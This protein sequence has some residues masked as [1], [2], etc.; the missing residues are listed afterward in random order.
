MFCPDCGREFRPGASFCDGCGRPVATGA[1]V[2]GEADAWGPA[3]G[4][5]EADIVC[6]VGEKSGYYLGNFRKFRVGRIE[7][8]APTWNWSAFL[9]GTWWF[10]YRKMYPWA[11]LAFV[12]SCIPIVGFAA[13]IATGIAGNYIYWRHVSAQI[14]KARTAT[15]ESELPAT[16][17][18]MGGVHAWVIWVGIAL[19]ILAFVGI[20]AAISIPMFLK[21]VGEGTRAI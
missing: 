11:L 3:P 13:W 8:F 12:L 9:F 4:A 20:L 10:L 18:Q 19:A 15:P 2:G 1:A 5:P 17:S 21:A 6:Y 14:A 7:A 16:L